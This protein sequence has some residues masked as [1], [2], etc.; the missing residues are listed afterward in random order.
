[1]GTRTFDFE[2]GIVGTFDVRFTVNDGRGGQDF[3]D[4]RLNVAAHPVM[5]NEVQTVP[6]NIEII[7]TGT[8][9]ADVSGWNV[10]SPPA[11]FAVPAATTIAA[12]GFLVIHWNQTGTDTASEKFTG[13][14]PALDATPQ[15]VLYVDDNLALSRRIRDFVKWA[16][17]PGGRVDQAVFAGQ[18]PTAS[19]ATGNPADGQS[20]ARTPGA[21]TEAPADWVVDPT[22]SIGSA[23]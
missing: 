23:N 20:T 16:S 4:V 7:N 3:E 12:G 21:N 5:L 11:C 1:M 18:W 13:S 15:V 9:A 8:A 17:P 19:S 22:P 14:Q 6:D 2:A 10:C